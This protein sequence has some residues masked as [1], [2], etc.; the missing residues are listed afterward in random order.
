MKVFPTETELGEELNAAIGRTIV[1]WSFIE[2]QFRKMCYMLLQISMPHGRIAVRS[3]RADE[4]LSMI[5]QIIAMDGYSVKSIDLEELSKSL[6]TLE[7]YR[8]LIAH[9]IWLKNPETGQL[10]V[11]D[12][13]GNWRPDP[14]S[15][16]VAKRIKP[17][18]VVVNASELN[19]LAEQMKAVSSAISIMHD[20]LGPQV[21]A[22]WNKRPPP[23]IPG[24]HNLD[25]T[26]AKPELQP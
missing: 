13:S 3:P 5:K 22:S 10:M 12:L 17:L 24:H 16:K 6:R 26:P 14:K 19:N 4:H 23:M 8:D 7:K 21:L 20:E 11:Q 1:H 2:G 9:G 18:G 15:P 25:Q